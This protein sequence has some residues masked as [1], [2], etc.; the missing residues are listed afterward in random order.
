MAIIYTRLLLYNH[1]IKSRCETNKAWAVSSGFKKLSFF[2]KKHC[3]L[4]KLDDDHNYEY[5]LEIPD[6]LLL[7]SDDIKN[8]VE[9][10]EK[11]NE[12]RDKGIN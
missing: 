4:I 12:Q 11:E 7:V 5:C 2:S 9:F 6:W 3:N 1:V 8:A 10:I